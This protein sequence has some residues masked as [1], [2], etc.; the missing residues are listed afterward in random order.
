MDCL[1]SFVLAKAMFLVLCML[2][3][4]IET[5]LMMILCLS[6][7]SLARSAWYADGSI[8]GFRNHGAREDLFNV[9]PVLGFG[10]E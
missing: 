3:L 6:L 7:D 9:L 5:R 1:R 4:R 2:I 8:D 10:L